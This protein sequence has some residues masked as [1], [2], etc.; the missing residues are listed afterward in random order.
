MSAITRLA[1]LSTLWLACGTLARDIEEC[2]MQMVAV[3]PIARW[4]IWLGKWL[5]LLSLNAALLAIV[6]RQRLWAA[7]VARDASARGSAEGSCATKCWCPG[8]R[9]KQADVSQQIQAETDRLLRERLQKSS[10][11]RADLAEV[12]KQIL[13]QVKAEYQIVPPGYCAHMGN[14][15]GIGPQ[16]AARPALATCALNSTPRTKAPRALSRASGSSGCRKKPALGRAKVD[17]PGAGY[18]S[19]IRDPANLF[20]DNGILTI[21]FRQCE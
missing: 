21:S 18:V 13:E 2:Q 11:T 10:V 20:D 1:G 8:A 14:R 12:R 7:A 19:R 4:Q 17:E 9:P 6:R 16:F 5:G 15:S 3:K